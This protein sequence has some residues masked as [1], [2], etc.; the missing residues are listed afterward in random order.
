MKTRMQP[1]G[2]AWQKLPRIVRDLCAEL[3]KEIELEM[4][5][6]ETELDRQVLE[7]VR[8]PLTHLVRNCADHGIESP[9]ARR[10]RRQA[11]ERARSGSPPVT[12]AATSSSR[13]PT[14]AAASTPRA[15]RPRPSSMG[16]AS[17]AETG[18]QNPMARSAISSSRRAFPPRRKSPAFPAAASA[19]TSCAAISSRSAA[20]STEVR[21]RRRHDLHDQDSADARHRLGAHR[22]GRRANVSPSRSSRCSSWCAP[23]VPASTASSGSRIRRCCGCAIN[24]CRS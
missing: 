14:T 10:R 12:R 8:D 7:L 19:W 9:A 17:E 18:R 13:S 11:A 15:S 1:I 3:G 4:H 20:P 23:A 24:C 6:A 5:G 16:L 2:N 21:C 22:R